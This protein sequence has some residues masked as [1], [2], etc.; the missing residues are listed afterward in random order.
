MDTVTAARTAPTPAVGPTD[1][2]PLGLLPTQ[3]LVADGKHE[4]IDMRQVQEELA[5][6][7]RYIESLQPQ[8][9]C[10]SS[11]YAGKPL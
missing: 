10:E 9:P 2:N 5:A 6:A 8:P 7:L 1:A 11:G 3:Q 4:V